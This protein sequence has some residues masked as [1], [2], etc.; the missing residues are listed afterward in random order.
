MK[1]ETLG[2]RAEAKT[3]ARAIIQCL[4]HSLELLV[5][6]REEVKLFWEILAEQAVCVL[7]QTALTR[8]ARVYKKLS[9][10]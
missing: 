1:W 7:I 5:R 2:R 3:F 4:D 8:T 10:P 9:R 6:D